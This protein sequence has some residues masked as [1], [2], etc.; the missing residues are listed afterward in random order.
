MPD[1]KC[2]HAV[3]IKQDEPMLDMGSMEFK[4]A[5]AMELHHLFVHRMALR[6]SDSRTAI[7]L[8]WFYLTWQNA[9]SK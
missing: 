7:V 1:V 3:Q 6:A 4:Y 9:M 8:E 5:I 2:V